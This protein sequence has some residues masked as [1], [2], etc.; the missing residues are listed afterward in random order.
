[1]AR[2]VPERTPFATI[3]DMPPPMRAMVLQA[4]ERMAADPQIQRVRAAAWRALDPRP[5]QRLLDA[6]CG[7][8]E[9]AR[10]LAAAV[11]PGG[12]VVGLDASAVAIAAAT[13][14]AGDVP[15]TFAVGDLRAL[16]FEDQ[17]FDGVRSERVLQHLDE[18]DA[19][20]AELVRVTRAGG[21]V[22]LVDTDWTSLV[23]DGLPDDM[24]AS[25]WQ[26][27]TVARQHHAT[28]G[29]TLRRRLVRAGLVDV[30]CEP[31]PLW[32]TDPDEAS[33]V[34]PVFNRSVP[35]EA[36]FIPEELWDPWWS[37]VDRAAEAGEL[38]AFVTIWVAAGVRP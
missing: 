34:I 15:V 1:M 32:F 27:A 14:R 3:D 17:T 9:V 10:D 5:G 24:V 33:T 36:G 12:E 11:A 6:G 7:L 30:V 19:A 16:D 23:S 26:R 38:L 13:E 8:G 35:R 2:E 20:V 4:L 21:R 18:P 25:M 37:E 29:R 31:V 22:C 28:M